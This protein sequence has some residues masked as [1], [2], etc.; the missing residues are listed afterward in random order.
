MTSPQRGQ[1]ERSRSGVRS[2]VLNQGIRVETRASGTACPRTR[3]GT[4]AAGEAQPP[5]E[6][7][8]CGAAATIAPL[9]IEGEK[10][11]A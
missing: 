8:C 11:A 9:Q 4:A 6:W 2:T 5:D 3:E 1:G 7:G 10:L